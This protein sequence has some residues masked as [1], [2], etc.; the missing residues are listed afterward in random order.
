[1]FVPV[2]QDAELTAGRFDT[3]AVFYSRSCVSTTAHAPTARC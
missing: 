3:F 2:Q 1:M